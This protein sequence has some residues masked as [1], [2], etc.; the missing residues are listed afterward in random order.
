MTDPLFD[1]ERLKPMFAD[2]ALEAAQ[3]SVDQPATHFCLLAIR[4]QAVLGV[5]IGWIDARILEFTDKRIG[6]L[7]SLAVAEEARRQ[8]IGRQL[9]A[10]ARDWMETRECDELTVSTDLGNPANELYQAEGCRQHHQ[11]VT[12]ILPLATAE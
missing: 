7:W 2:G 12:W 6:T 11:L 9:F 4:D 1:T 10:A 5:A 3:L 8:G